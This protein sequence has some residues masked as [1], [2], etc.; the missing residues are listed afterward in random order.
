MIGPFK[1]EPVRQ[2]KTEEERRELKEAIAQWEGRFGQNYPLWVDG[3]KIETEKKHASINPS[4]TSEIIGYVS[5]ADRH[6]VDQAMA[7]AWEAFKTWSRVEPEARA[8]VLLRA[9]GIM[10]RRR[11]ELVAIE[12]LEAGKPVVEADADVA[13]AI[14]FLEYYAREMVRLAHPPAPVQIPGESNEIRYI[15]LGVGVIIPPWNF[16]LAILTGMSSSAIVTGNTI[17]LKPASNTPIIGSLFV[18]IMHQAGLPEGVIQFIPGSGSEIGDYLV[19]H[20]KTRF[21]S[22]TGSKDV[23]LRIWQRAAV[24]QEGQKW[25]KRVVAEMGGKDAIIVDEDA[26]LDAAAEGIVISAFGF[27]GQKCS[28]ASRVIAVGSAYEPLLEKV[29]ER[30]RKLTVGDP[31]DLDVDLGPII[32][33]SQYRKILDYIEVGKREG[34]HLL[35]GE[36]GPTDGYFIRPAIFGDVPPRAR[37]AQEEIFGPVL[38]F[39]RAKDFDEAIHIANDTDYGLTGAVYARRMEHLEKARAE[40]HVG[41]L[42][43]N[44]K[45]TGALVGVQPFGGFNLSGTDAKAGGPDYL[46]NFLQM[47][48]IAERL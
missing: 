7:S 4:K 34:K 16:P 47:K 35:G 14:D 6:I 36:R 13:E 32:D 28:A 12:M 27:Q 29:L 22:F 31:R 11:A 26:D 38:A 46:L 19:D 15:P 25:L 41:N 42:Y 2:Y 17:L 9:A 1:N 30:T 10:R 45:C 23:G 48:S 43:F 44:R 33:E 39:I 8:R 40:F 21:I 18:E 37:I 20:P 24:H 5:Q 3:R